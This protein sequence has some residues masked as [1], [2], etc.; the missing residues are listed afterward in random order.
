MSEK[1]PYRSIGDL[2]FTFP[3]FLGTIRNGIVE[4]LVDDPWN[5]MSRWGIK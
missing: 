3:G 2:D 5:P 1:A 4:I